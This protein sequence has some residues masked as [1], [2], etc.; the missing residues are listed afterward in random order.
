MEWNETSQRLDPGKGTALG[1]MF[2]MFP[3]QTLNLLGSVQN[4]SIDSSR[5]SYLVR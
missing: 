5:C 4:I 2:R 1:I 3:E